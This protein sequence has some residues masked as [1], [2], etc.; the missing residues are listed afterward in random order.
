LIQFTS[1]HKPIF[2]S[3]KYQSVSLT[4][5]NRQNDAFR[6]T[7]R[8]DVAELAVS[9]QSDGL[10]VPP[11]L[12]MEKH[13]TYVIVSGF[14]RVA[15]C[16]KLGC[17][18]IDARMLDS[19]TAPLACL[20]LAIAEN[21]FQRQLNLI[22]ISRAL[23]K[24]ASFFGG[25]H[26]L[27]QAASTLGLPANQSIIKKIKD[28]C[29]LPWSVQCSI[30]NEAISLSMA[31]ELGKLD[32]ESALAFAS[33]FDQLK[34][35]L[36]KQKEILTLAAEIARR[37]NNSVRHVI[38]APRLQMIIDDED[39]DRAQKERQIRACLRQWRFPQ[40]VEAEKNYQI[41]HKQLKLGSD[42]KLIPPKGFEGNTFALNLNFTS[43]AHLRQLRD[44]IDQLIKHPSLEKIIERRETF[45]G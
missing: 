23:Q 4:R 3:A 26:Q 35:S 18:E 41:H 22:E 10:I 37:E 19:K 30:L 24:L 6:I 14:R 31:V 21:A 12:I 17:N 39:L 9:I 1:M 44:T 43:L 42:I 13:S 33:L 28:L 25:D 5:I 20:R 16:Q 15:A 45:A 2:Q 11:T 32:P 27:A 40:I 34:F 38:K 8:E 29:L 36:N 7:T